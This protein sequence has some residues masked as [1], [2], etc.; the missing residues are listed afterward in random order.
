MPIN[1]EGLKAQN[2]SNDLRITHD[3]KM[4][5]MFEKLCNH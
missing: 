1:V 2:P 5:Q 3:H 4:L